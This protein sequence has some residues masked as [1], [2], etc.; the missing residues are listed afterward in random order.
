MDFIFE[1]GAVIGQ[2]LLAAHGLAM[3]IVNLTPTPADDSV[4]AKFYK[5]IEWLA[6]LL[7]S[8]AKK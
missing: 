4:V 3:L 7:T 1:H 6:G 2:A 8:L 5:P